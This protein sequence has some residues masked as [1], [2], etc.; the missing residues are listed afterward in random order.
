VTERGNGPDARPTPRRQRPGVIELAAA[1]LIVGGVLQLIGAFGAAASLPAGAEVVFFVTVAIDIAT[2]LAGIL[3]RTG[4]LW[5][6]VVNYVAVLGFLDLTRA[7]SS[8]VA[9][10]LAIGDIVVVVIV[11]M[12]RAWFSPVTPVTRDATSP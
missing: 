4:R 8:P 1:L 11:V 10:M 9:L 7:G 5:L 12:N 6:L 2:I 3:I